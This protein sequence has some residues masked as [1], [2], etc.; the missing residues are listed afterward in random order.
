MTKLIEQINNIREQLDKLERMMMMNNVVKLPWDEAPEW[1]QW[2]AMD[3]DGE[4]WWYQTEP[5][6]SHILWRHTTGLLC[7]FDFPPCTNWKESKR[8]RS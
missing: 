6:V 7:H 8:Q 5:E 4:W 3:A 2:A 1:A